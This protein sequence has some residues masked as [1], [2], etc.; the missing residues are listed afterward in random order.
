MPT[1]RSTGPD[2]WVRQLVQMRFGNR[3][4]RCGRDGASIQHRM[5]RQSGGTRDPAINCPSNLLWVCGD[6][7]RGCHGH[8]E[9]YRT[10]AY[11]HGWLVHRGHEPS[12]QPVSLWDGR[13]VLL[14]NEGGWSHAAEEG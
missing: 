1:R 13:R 4:A 2:F 12:E 14:D 8:M 7:V 5:P 10:E 3:C 9:S 6:G 11:A